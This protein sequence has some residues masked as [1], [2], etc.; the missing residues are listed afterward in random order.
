MTPK[1]LSHAE[2]SEP[3]L[4]PARATPYSDTTRTSLAHD[5]AF[6]VA[7]L[8]ADL[9]DHGAEIA[10]V[11]LESDPLGFPA[12][13]E[14]W[15]HDLPCDLATD[16][17]HAHGYPYLARCAPSADVA[18]EP[19]RTRLAARAL[20]D[21]RADRSCELRTYDPAERARH[22]KRVE[23]NAARYARALEAA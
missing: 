10:R 13:Y 9:R 12:L 6:L 21:V 16:A 1:A 14:R 18:D 3:A 17:L 5:L 7:A 15:R 4:S 2:P 22:A 19:V 8:P 23:V 11:V 20:L